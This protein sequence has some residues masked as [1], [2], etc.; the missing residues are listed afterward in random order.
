MFGSMNISL[1]NYQTKYPNMSK[2]MP[3]TETNHEKCIINDPETLNESIR[4]AIEESCVKLF[5]DNPL[6]SV[7]IKQIVERAGVSRSSFYRNYRSKEDI[8]ISYTNRL[9]DNLFADHRMIQGLFDPNKI[10]KLIVERNRFIRRNGS[11]FSALVRDRLLY[12]TLM[13]L[14]RDNKKRM[15]GV[16]FKNDHYYSA[17]TIGGTAAIIEEWIKSGFK[18][19]EEWLARYTVNY[20]KFTARVLDNI[21]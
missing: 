21:E 17:Q 16:D 4:E 19:S 13:N 2:K 7:T 6:D 14:S 18:E 12:G 15:F 20:M 5:I 1:I 3:K 10:E 8:V 11:F 9:Y